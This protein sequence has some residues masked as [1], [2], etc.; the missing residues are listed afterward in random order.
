MSIYTNFVDGV[1]RTFLFFG[2]TDAALKCLTKLI[3]DNLVIPDEFNEAVITYDCA[4][5][6]GCDELDS[7]SYPLRFYSRDKKN[8]LWLSA[9]S[10]GYYGTG[11][12]G[13]LR[14]LALMGF[15]ITKKEEEEIF[16]NKKINLRIEKK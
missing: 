14:A 7:S 12:H 1:R 4:K 10:A 11:P 9:V 16:T 5:G 15:E 2:S 8:E 6:I 3:N 13:T